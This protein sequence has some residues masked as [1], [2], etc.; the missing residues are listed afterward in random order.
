MTQK[1]PLDMNNYKSLDWKWDVYPLIADLGPIPLTSIVILS[2]QL[3]VL[4]P[5]S[6]SVII[7]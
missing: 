5:V 3:L 4:V 2:V 1:V 6:T 7:P